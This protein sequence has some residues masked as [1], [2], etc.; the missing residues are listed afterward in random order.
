MKDL[1]V[2]DGDWVVKSGK[3]QEVS[4][5]AV[6]KQRLDRLIR[7][8]QGELFYSQTFGSKITDALH[9]GHLQ[10]DLNNLQSAL[11]T[12]ESVKETDMEVKTQDP[13][14]LEIEIILMNGNTLN[15]T[16]TL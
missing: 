4:D 7:T 6:I 10:H 13:L 1:Q 14:V 11:E 3:V 15:H 2:K 16:L 8:Y 12:D 9:S 5:D